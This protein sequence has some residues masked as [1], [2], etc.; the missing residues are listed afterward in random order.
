MYNRHITYPWNKILGSQIW[1][2]WSK[3]RTKYLVFTIIHRT[4][5][6]RVIV[7]V[8]D[9]LS[10]CINNY[11]LNKEQ[12]SIQSLDE[13]GGIIKMIY[14]YMHVCTDNTQNWR[15]HKHT[16]TYTPYSSSV[17][18]QLVADYYCSSYY[19]SK[20]ITHATH[21]LH[22]HYTHTT[23]TAIFTFTITSGCDD[24]IKSSQPVVINM[25]VSIHAYLSQHTCT[26]N[27]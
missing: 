12:L 6:V 11:S 16:H 3:S 26:H 13:Y 24:L 10:M 5:P 21:T 22:T 14:V 8:T 27:I 23:H 15:T 25:H 2:K 18:D 9:N 1:F 17:T 4:F 19:G 20:N 7:Q